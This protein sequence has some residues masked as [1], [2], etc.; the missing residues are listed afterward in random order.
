MLPQG[1]HCYFLQLFSLFYFFASCTAASE[2]STTTAAAVVVVVCAGTCASLSKDRVYIT[3]RLSPLGLVDWIL[4]HN[5][6][7]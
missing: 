6:W 7:L 2:A 4:K 3:Q 5:V 1:W